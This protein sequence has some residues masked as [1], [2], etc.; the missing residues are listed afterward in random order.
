MMSRLT[1]WTALVLIMG[2]L[3]VF[4]APAV[5]LAPTAMRAWRAAQMA[6]LAMVAAATTLLMLGIPAFHSEPY[7]Q[8]LEKI[9]VPSADLVVLD[10]ARLC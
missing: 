4:A 10:C 9:S 3:V 2:V 7:I 5:N 1:F 8:V 6:V